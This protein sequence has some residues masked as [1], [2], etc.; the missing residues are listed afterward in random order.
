MKKISNFVAFKTKNIL[1]AFTAVVFFIATSSA[2][3]AAN[4][5]YQPLVGLPRCKVSKCSWSRIGEDSLPYFKYF[6][7]HSTKMTKR[8]EKDAKNTKNSNV[9][10]TSNSTKT[11]TRKAYDRL[12]FTNQMLHEIIEE[13]RNINLYSYALNKAYKEFLKEERLGQIY[14]ELRLTKKIEAARLLFPEYKKQYE[15]RA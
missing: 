14:T 5:G 4:I 6:I 3:Y 7:F 12:K 11:V 8:S 9:L 13:Q 15:K 1:L 2:L 10:R